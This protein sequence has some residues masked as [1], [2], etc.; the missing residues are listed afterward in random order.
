MRR[1]A[2]VTGAGRRIGADIARRLAREG[3]AVALTANASRE[4]AQRLAAEIALAGG[5]ARVYPADLAEPEAA[6][7]AFALA[8]REFGPIDLLVNNAA[9]FEAD[10]L[11][12]L[13][14]A[15]WRRQFAVDL[16]APVFLTGAFVQAL[17]EGA[18]G[19]VVNIIDQRVLK[20]TPQYLSYTLAKSALWTATRT[21]AQALAPRIRVNA[22]G[23]GPTYASA[24]EGE[25]GLSHEA[26]GTLLGRAV[27]GEEIAE[28]VV[29]LAGARS[30]T[31]QLIA[32]DSGQH[33]GWRTPDIVDDAS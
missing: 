19:A 29:Y 12:Q 3:Y 7:A 9:A 22:V 14:L 33:L 21:L 10:S 2:F 11:A 15:L 5:E 31:G 30:V 18:E 16:E 24:R 6:A 4:G 28:A 25:A 13:D 27:S 32:V 23:P 17:P 1:V 8:A 20:L 26:R